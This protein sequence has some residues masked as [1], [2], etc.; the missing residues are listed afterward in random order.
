MKNENVLCCIND[1]PLF[2]YNPIS[3]KEDVIRSQI[4][5]NFV[6]EKSAYKKWISKE[7]TFESN[8]EF[9]YYEINVEEAFRYLKENHKIS[10]NSI[11]RFC[12]TFLNYFLQDSPKPLINFL[13]KTGNYSD[14]ELK[15][16]ETLFA[17]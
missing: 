6:T 11:E 2:S 5:I 8:V 12:L 15:S 16:F 14:K 7:T 1:C 10:G 9:Y 4:I 3:Q 17:S 13:R